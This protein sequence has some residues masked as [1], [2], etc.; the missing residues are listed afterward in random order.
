MVLR[1]VGQTLRAVLSSGPCYIAITSAKVF[2]PWGMLY[3][4]PIADEKLTQD[5]SNWKKEG[6]WGYQ[7]IVQQSPENIDLE[8]GIR[9]DPAKSAILSVNFDDR[10]K[11]PF[12]DT[13]IAFIT[14]LAHKTHIKRTRK[15]ELQIAFMQERANLEQILYFYCHGHGSNDN[16]GVNLKAPSLELTDDVVTASDFEDWSEGQKLPTSPLLFIN[17]CQGGQMQTM[18]YESFAVELLGRERRG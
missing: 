8:N 17:A 7:H 3:T 16:A 11:L 13:H 4:H 10:L 5:G 18:F 15:I 12:I 6:F 9:P 2:L 1:K 14:A